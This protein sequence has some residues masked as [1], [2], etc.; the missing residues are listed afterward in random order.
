M[1]VT[2]R[3]FKQSIILV[4]V[5]TSPIKHVFEYI[6]LV[7]TNEEITKC[8]SLLDGKLNQGIIS[9]N[10]FYLS[11]VSDY[12]LNNVSRFGMIDIP[13]IWNLNAAIDYIKMGFKE[14]LTEWAAVFYLIYLRI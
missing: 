1:V 4:Y 10:Q 6:I 2:I 8:I 11:Q 14:L 5:D 9:F 13:T 12:I 3:D 7:L